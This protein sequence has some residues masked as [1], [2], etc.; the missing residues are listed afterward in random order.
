MTRWWL[1]CWHSRWEEKETH[2]H[3]VMTRWW[4]EKE[5]QCVIMTRWWSWLP[6]LLVGGKRNPPMSHNG[7][8][9]VVAASVICRRRQIN[10]S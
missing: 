7:S 1:S 5:T 2:Q 8:L 3:V 4:E 10:E 9:V 6:A